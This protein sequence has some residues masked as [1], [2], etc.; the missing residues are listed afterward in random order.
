MTWFIGVFIAVCVVLVASKPLR[1]E[2]FN[3]TDGVIA[4][5]CG[6]RGLTIAMAQATIRSWGRRVPGWLLLGGLAGAAGLQAFYPLAELVIKLAVVV[7]LVDETGLGATHTDATAW[8]NLVMTALIW[9][10]PGALLG[11][12]AMQYRRRAGVR[13]RWVLLGIV[14]GLAFLGS[15]GVVIG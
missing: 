8:F 13:F 10:V 12:S 4:L 14:G 5:A 9:G 3:G 2:S 11:R 15:L 7:G 6:L 1:G